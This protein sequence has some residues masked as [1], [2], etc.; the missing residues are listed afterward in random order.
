MTKLL[1]HLKPMV[2]VLLVVVTLLACGAMAELYLP[3]LMADII[4]DGIYL[5]YEPAY[6]HMEMENPFGDIDIDF[7]SLVYHEGYI[8]VFEMEDGFSTVDIKTAWNEKFTGGYNIEFNFKDIPVN[9]SEEL[10]NGILS[11]KDKKKI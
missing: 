1:K 10:F 3:G 4:N 8:P 9:D 7:E 11:T 5:D 2:K 6:V